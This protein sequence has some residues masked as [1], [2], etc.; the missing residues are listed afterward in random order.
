[1]DANKL[2][3]LQDIK[4]N[5]PMVC[6]RC[7]E[8]DISSDGWGVCLKFKYYHFK[9]GEYRLLS[10]HMLGSCPAF[11]ENEIPDVDSFKGYL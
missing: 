6:G 1:M 7:T 8:S 2:K 11:K 9:H 5:F 3:V 10:I 4:Y